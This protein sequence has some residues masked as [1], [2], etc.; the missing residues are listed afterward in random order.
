MR[1]PRILVACGSLS[2]GVE[3]TTFAAAGKVGLWTKA[4]AC[5]SF[6]LPQIETL[7]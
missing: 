3:D 5:T 1:G 7:R 4:D 6:T 2:L